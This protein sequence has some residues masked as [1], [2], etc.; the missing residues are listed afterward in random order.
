MIYDFQP[1]VTKALEQLLKTETDYNAIIYIG[2]EPDFKEFHVHSNIL[3]CRSEY[4]D[5]IFSDK[6][7][8][9][10]DEKYVIKKSNI[11]PQAFDVILK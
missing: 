4:F 9:K 1:E 11:T 6:S 8:E 3:R 5:N 10:K 7:I 2:K